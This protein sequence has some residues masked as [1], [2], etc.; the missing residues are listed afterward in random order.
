MSVTLSSGAN[1]R[2][3]V[4][5]SEFFATPLKKLTVEEN[6]GTGRTYVLKGDRIVAVTVRQDE[7][8]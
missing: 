6:E 5:S 3:E 4:A 8:S 7:R 2:I 1:V